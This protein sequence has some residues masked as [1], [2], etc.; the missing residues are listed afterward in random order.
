MTAAPKAAAAPTLTK[1]LAAAPL[2]VAVGEDPVEVPLLEPDEV[3]DAEPLTPEASGPA[4]ADREAV[5]Q[6]VS[7]PASTTKGAD[8]PVAPLLSFKFK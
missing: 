1:A 2:L 6:S 7:E 3:V 4:L 5:T 8:W